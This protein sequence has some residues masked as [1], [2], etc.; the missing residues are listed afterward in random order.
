MVCV[1]TM[2]KPTKKK[3]A[4]TRMSTVIAPIRVT[5]LEKVTIRKKAKAAKL[6]VAEFVRRRAL[7]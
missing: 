7:A 4:D 1:R 6:N 3:S 5:K 2:K